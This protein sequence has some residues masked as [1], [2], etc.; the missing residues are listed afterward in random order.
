M[1]DKSV[2]AILTWMRE[3]VWERREGFLNPARTCGLYWEGE[4]DGQ[5]DLNARLMLWG[6]FN[7]LAE[8]RG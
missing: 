8:P 6:L 3:A 2:N 1:L 7:L 4:K 5:V